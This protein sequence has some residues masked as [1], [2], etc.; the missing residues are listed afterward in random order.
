[1]TRFWTA[2]PVATFIGAIARRMAA[3]PR[4]SSGLVGSSIQ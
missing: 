4:M 1:M 2:S 3:W